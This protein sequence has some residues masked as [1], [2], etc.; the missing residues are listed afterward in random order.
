M[1]FGLH[2]KQQFEDIEDETFQEIPSMHVHRDFEQDFNKL[3]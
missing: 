1:S 3:L 2:R